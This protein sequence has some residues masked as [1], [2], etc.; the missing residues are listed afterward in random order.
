MAVTSN[1]GRVVGATI[2]VKAS[3]PTVRDDNSKLL[4]GDIWINST[5][6]Q[7]YKY[8][9]GTFIDT[10]INIK[11]EKG[12]AGS[13]LTL[14]ETSSTAYAGNKGK[15]NADN[16]S[17]I[18]GQLGRLGPLAEGV[19]DDLNEFKRDYENNVGQKIEDKV[20]TMIATDE[21]VK[22]ALGIS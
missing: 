19:R 17:D 2:I 12:D 15:Q 4:E 16:I 5:N 3:Q 14:G 6:Q 7:L 22:A 9:G 13:S 20:E 18:Y 21:E 1:L 8:Q 11:G 10:G